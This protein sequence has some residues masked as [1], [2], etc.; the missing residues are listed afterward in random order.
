VGRT[1]AGAMQSG[2]YY[3]Y[4]GLVDGILER[5]AAEIPGLASVVATGGQAA[6]IATG[7]RHIREVDPL[8]TLKGLKII[9]E[10]NRRRP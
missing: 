8:L 2:I 7:S 5:L 9:Y 3:G 4:I 10:R 6:L 1:T